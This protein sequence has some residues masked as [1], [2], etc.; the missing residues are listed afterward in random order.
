MWLSNIV[1]PNESARFAVG[2]HLRHI[3]RHPQAWSQPDSIPRD[4]EARAM[5]NLFCRRRRARSI[6]MM[7]RIGFWLTFTSSSCYND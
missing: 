6:Y 7:S 4:C 2:W 3:T 1:I 5:F